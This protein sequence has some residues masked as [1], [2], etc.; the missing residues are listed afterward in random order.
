MTQEEYGKLLGIKRCTVGAYEENRAKVP[1]D[2]I[3]KVMD[4]AELPMED[5]Y[6]FVFDN[7]YNKH[8]TI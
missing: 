2:L 8:I 4:V 6:D 5:M 3:P 7:K 1:V